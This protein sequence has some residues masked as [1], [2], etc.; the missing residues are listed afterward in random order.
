MNTKPCTNPSQK[1]NMDFITW[2]LVAF[3]I[4]VSYNMDWN[5]V[6]NSFIPAVA[7]FIFSGSRLAFRFA[8]LQ[9]RKLALSMDQMLSAPPIAMQPPVRAAVTRAAAPWR[10]NAAAPVSVSASAAAALGDSSESTDFA[11]SSE[12]EGDGDCGSGES[13]SSD[14]KGTPSPPSLDE[15]VSSPKEE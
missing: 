12:E 10:L 11:S 13:Q 5:Y 1:G 3:L 7:A 6:L 9:A 4:S 14:G 2:I 8:S 15:R